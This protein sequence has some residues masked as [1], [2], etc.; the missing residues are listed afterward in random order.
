MTKKIWSRD[1]TAQQEMWE[2]EGK[3]VIVSQVKLKG[4]G[5]D[6]YETMCFPCDEHGEVTSYFD[7]ACHRGLYKFIRT[8][9]FIEDNKEA[10]VNG[11]RPD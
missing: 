3:Y 9:E 6:P 2:V 8:D 4:S 11:N 5:L 10:I 1:R 7:L